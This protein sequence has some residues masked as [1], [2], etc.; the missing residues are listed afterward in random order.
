MGSLLA[1]GQ[2][3][4]CT[5]VLFAP[6]RVFTGKARRLAQPARSNRRFAA[7]AKL[8]A[9]RVCFFFSCLQKAR[10]ACLVTLP[11][12]KRAFG[13][14]NRCYGEKIQEDKGAQEGGGGKNFAHRQNEGTL[15]VK[16]LIH[17][18]NT[19][20]HRMT[21]PRDIYRYGRLPSPEF[22]ANAACH[23]RMLRVKSS[24]SSPNT[25]NSKFAP[26]FPSKTSRQYE[27]A[28][29]TDT[30]RWKQ[31][32]RPVFYT[33]RHRSP[34]RLHCSGSG[35]APLTS[36]L[37]CARNHHDP[38]SSLSP[39]SSSALRSPTIL[40]HE[41][42]ADV[43]YLLQKGVTLVVCFPVATRGGDGSPNDDWVRSLPYVAFPPPPSP[44][45]RRR[46]DDRE[47]GKQK[48]GT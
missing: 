48:K 23:G 29:K 19:F 10:A 17:Q 40:P 42:M 46:N 6:R 15:P 24:T 36:Q 39:P 21:L 1:I 4:C 3:V 41:Q 44:T 45:N 11:R 38:P 26:A 25:G 7:H 31:N 37:Q 34:P 8:I 18:K 32:S 27:K 5:W 30:R 35:D 14:Q 28:K 12:S 22:I 47:G 33:Q 9:V 13:W 20:E 16:P 43:R 2:G